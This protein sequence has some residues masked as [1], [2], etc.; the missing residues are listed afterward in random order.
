MGAHVWGPAYLRDHILPHWRLSGWAPDWYAGFPMYQFYMVHPRRWPWC[1]W[2]SCCPTGGA[3][4]G[5]RSP[6]CSRCRS[7]AWAFGKLSGLRFPLPAMFSAMSV[8]FL[9]DESFRSTAATSHR[10]W[11]ASSRSRSR[12]RSRSSTSACFAYGLRTG[13]HRALAA[14]LLR[15][16]RACATCIVSVLRGDGHRRAGSCSY[17]DRRRLKWLATMVP[18]GALLTRVLGR[19]VLP[20]P[21]L[22]HRH[23]LRA[24]QPTT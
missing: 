16:V 3:E 9:F 5:Q 23:V 7:A 10:R 12:C 24:A 21:P 15:A 14:V 8:I 13:K 11:R 1:W 17:L 4:A 18:V 22:P 20:A 2:T 19:A 6:A